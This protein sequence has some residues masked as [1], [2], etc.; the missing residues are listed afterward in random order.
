V[1]P[2]PCRDTRLCNMLF[3]RLSLLLSAAAAAAAAGPICG[4]ATLPLDSSRP[5]VLLIGDSISMTPPYTPG[6]YGH[7]LELLLAA[8]G[9]AVQHAGGNY[10]GGQCGD[11]RLGL[12]CTNASGTSA[13]SYLNF[14]GT[15]DLIHFN[16]GLHDLADYGPTLPQLPLPIYGRNIATIFARLAA[17]AKQVMWTSTTPCPDVPT[18]YNRSYTLVEEYNAQAIK[19]LPAGVLVN[20]LWTA[21]V[22]H[23]GSHYKSCD[24]QLPANVHL[25]PAG[26][27]FTAAVAAKDI[28]AALG[29]E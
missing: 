28:L 29:L 7:A 15:F 16:Y 9:V 13:Y 14:A 26:I 23:C 11:T 27:N 18:S 1:S 22:K 17:R 19:S 8:K 20:D 3:A 25:T 6:G 5:N 12:A 2:T 24:L 21:M 10:G 4:N